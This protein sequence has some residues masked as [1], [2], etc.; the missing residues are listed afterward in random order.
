MPQ[1]SRPSGCGQEDRGGRAA[2][3]PVAHGKQRRP[4]ERAAA[5]PAGERE[6][7]AP[8]GLDASAGFAR[9][10]IRDQPGP[11]GLTTVDLLILDDFALEPMSKEESKDVREE[12]VRLAVKR[13]T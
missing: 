2:V 12:R 7:D 5:R 3:E 1:W 10:R 8:F 11:V 4:D 9:A 13:F 6:R